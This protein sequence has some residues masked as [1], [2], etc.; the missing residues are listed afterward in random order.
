MDNYSYILK[1]IYFKIIKEMKIKMGIIN[2]NLPDD[3]EESFREAVFHRFGMKRGNINKAVEE[4]IKEW[5][6]KKNGRKENGK[7]T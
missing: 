7:K 3:L 4:A 6:N 5:I 1:I 2:A